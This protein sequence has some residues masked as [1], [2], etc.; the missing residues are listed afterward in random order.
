MDLDLVEDVPLLV[1]TACVFHNFCLFNEDVADFLDPCEED[2]VN[3]FENI[4]WRSR[5]SRE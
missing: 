5:R 1:I 3:N 2:E 4:F